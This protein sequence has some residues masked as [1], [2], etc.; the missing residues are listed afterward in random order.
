MPTKFTP[1]DLSNATVPM[2]VDEMA[3]L[4]AVEAYVKKLRGIYKEA[5]YARADIKMDEMASQL[6]PVVNEGELFVAS[7]AYSSPSRIKADLV[8]ELLSPDDLAKVTENGEQLTTRFA[9]KQG[10]ENPV[11]NELFESLKKE[12]DL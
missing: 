8:R 10:V 4:A 2:L 11:V 9:L 3:K 6:D 7:T 5:Y 12:L 1:P